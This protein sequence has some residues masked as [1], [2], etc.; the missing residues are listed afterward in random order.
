M[1]QCNT[2]SNNSM[3]KF[4][5]GENVRFFDDV[6]GEGNGNVI[7][8]R[9]I[10]GINYYVILPKVQRISNYPVMIIEEKNIVSTPF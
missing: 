4:D 5:N 2:N 1:E 3:P 8:F 6:N 10:N 7:G 9:K